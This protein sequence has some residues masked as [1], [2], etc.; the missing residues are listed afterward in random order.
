MTDEADF[1]QIPADPLWNDLPLDL[2]LGNVGQG[3]W[4]WADTQA[5]F[6]L[7]YWSSFDSKTVFALIYDE[8]H[9]SLS[10]SMLYEAA[11]P[12]ETRLR[13]LLDN[14]T[15]YNGALLRFFLRNPD[16][17]LLANARQILAAPDFFL[18]E[19]EKLG[20]SISPSPSS[21]NIPASSRSMPPMPKTPALQDALAVHTVDPD[22][23]MTSLRA[24]AAESFILDHVLSDKTAC[25][26][27]YDELQA[28][29]HF[30]LPAFKPTADRGAAAW[31]ALIA[32]RRATC[33]TIT[34]L[35]NERFLLI[36]QLHQLQEEFE[37]FYLK[38]KRWQ[39][40]VSISRDGRCSEAADRVKQQLSYKVGKTVVEKSRTP[41]GCLSMPF[42][43]AKVISAHRRQLRKSPGKKLQPI[44]T[45]ADAAEADRIKNQLS[46]RVG[47]V[48]VK[49]G[50]KPLSWLK[51]PFLI[52]REYRDF[53]ASR[54]KVS[55]PTS[56]PS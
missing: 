5:I 1:Q 10:E 25:L 13:F 14:W 32:Q 12:D 50:A 4:G 42:A 11:E 2:T 15:A 48:L 56:R 20:S 43:L 46:Y 38:D 41:G 6:C 16:R 28:N 36:T 21:P 49:H 33:A 8:P 47:N 51:L 52:H 22:A 24:E 53:H 29:A 34:Q 44:Q 55:K 54:N 40:P 19:L 17:C 18:S 9:H 7:E 39:K 3:L 45:S 37:K 27:M 23:A 35:H 26:Q 30:P 31:L